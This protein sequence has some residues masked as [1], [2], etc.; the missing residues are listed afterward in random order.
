MRVADARKALR[1]ANS[2][3]RSS[4]L[5]Q[6]AGALPSRSWWPL[7]VREWSCL[8]LIP[9]SAYAEAFANNRSRWQPSCMRGRNQSL[10]QR[11]PETLTVYRGQDGDR[12]NGLSWTLSRRVAERFAAG[13]R[14]IANADP[15]VLERQISRCDVAFA[16]ADRGEAE[17][18]LWGW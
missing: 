12:A 16:C 11:L 14:G 4:L 13:H 10:Y 7:I 3:E 5:L 8:D 2:V 6:L 15:Q 9:H 1:W 18:V 17:I